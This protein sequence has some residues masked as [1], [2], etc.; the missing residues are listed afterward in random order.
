MRLRE[1][2]EG[3]A[4]LAITTEAGHSG[5]VMLFIFCAESGQRL[6]GLCSALLVED[7]LEFRFKLGMAFFRNVAQDVLELM[8]DTALALAAGKLLVNRIE[9]G[10]VAVRDPQVHLLQST[11]L[12]LS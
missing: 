8:G 2:I 12:E 6:V 5:R 3:Q 9:H 11:L 10:L 4:G 1:V 7:G